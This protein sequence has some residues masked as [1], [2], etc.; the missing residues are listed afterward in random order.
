MYIRAAAI[1]FKT[2]LVIGKNHAKCLAKAKNSMEQGFLTNTGLFVNRIEALEIAL[3]AGQ[4]ITKHNP[5]DK[6]LSEDLINDKRFTGAL[7]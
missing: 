5:I 3:N 4:E 7:T 1:R 2:D 6:L